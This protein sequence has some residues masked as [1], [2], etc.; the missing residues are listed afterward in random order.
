MPP[1][2]KITTI[3]ELAA[4]ITSI[5]ARK[6]ARKIVHCHGVFDLLHVGHIRHFEQAKKLGDILVVTVTPDMYVNKG[7][8]HP[9]F[10]QDLRVEGIASLSCVDYVAINNW[11]TAVETIKLLKPDIY[12]K[13][14][15]YK[16]RQADL[17]GKISEEEAAV[18]FS[19]GK[20]AFT[21]DITFSSSGLINRYLPVLP[22]EVQEYLSRFA[23]RHSTSDVLR[24]LQNAESLKVLVVGDAIIDEYQYCTAIGTST[25]EPALAVRY[26]ST[27]KFAGGI[28]AVANHVANFC[29]QVGMLTILGSQDSQEDFIRQ[30]VSSNVEKMFLYKENSPTIVKRRYVESYLLQKLF[31]VYEINDSELS[32]K[33]DQALCDILQEV[34]PRYDV[35]IA[36]DYGHGM[37]TRNAVE[38]LCRE[39]PFLAVNTQVNAGNRG[40]NTISK[41]SRADFISLT[42]VEIA[43]EEKNQQGDLRQMIQSVARKLSCGKILTTCGKDGNI[44]YSAQEGFFEVPAF[45]GQVVDRIGAGDAVLSLT[46][47]CVP[48]QAPMEIVGFIGN[49]VGAQAVSML[50]RRAG[51]DRVALFKFIEALL[52]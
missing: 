14:P 29:R 48:Q 37:M 8:H 10:T 11:P 42:R 12:V 49:V 22:R 3:E 2:D 51:I 47:L 36:V 25:K 23:K 44:C 52:K 39:A 34:I 33:Q 31:E 46:S 43:L 20:I 4:K 6:S 7:P 18:K 41:Y 50:G 38:V 30:N 35:V 17:T 40:Y 27:E 1:N 45:A 28:L 15:D 21:D 26:L 16:D 19:G 5:R 32:Q 24:Y 13:G 9:A